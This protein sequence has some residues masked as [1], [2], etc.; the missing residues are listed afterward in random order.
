AAT[1]VWAAVESLR[2]AGVPHGAPL[3]L[4]PGGGDGWLLLRS[5]DLL[6]GTLLAPVHELSGPAALAVLLE[7]GHEGV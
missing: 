2:K 1:R 6:I 4:H 7:A 3:T 5:G